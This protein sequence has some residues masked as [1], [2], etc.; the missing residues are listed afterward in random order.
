[1]DYRR[2]GEEEETRPSHSQIIVF[3][4][5]KWQAVAVAAHSCMHHQQITQGD[6]RDIKSK[7][8]DTVMPIAVTWSISSFFLLF[9]VSMACDIVSDRPFPAFTCTHTHTQQWNGTWKIPP[10]SLSLSLYLNMG[11]KKKNKSFVMEERYGCHRKLALV[12]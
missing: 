7:V 6:A 10:P 4:K 5:E 3:M 2:R 11:N 9:R 12:K 8:M 1:M